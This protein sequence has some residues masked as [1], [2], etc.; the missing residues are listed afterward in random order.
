Q[1]RFVANAAHELRTPV[2]HLLAEAQ[3]LARQ[4]R[5]AAEMERFTSSVQAEM[6]SMSQIVESLL[7]LARADAGV[8]AG[9]KRAGSGNGVVTEA[10]ERCNAHARQREMPLVPRLPEGLSEDPEVAGDFDLLVALVSNLLRN[11]IRFSPPGEPVEI[12][13]QLEAKVVV[14][15]VR[16]RG[17]G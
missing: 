5:P 8:S 11:A 1:E 15:T 4:S 10:I 16:D 3:V 12:E 9:G 14:V 17:P 2:T 13:V 7:L 6:R